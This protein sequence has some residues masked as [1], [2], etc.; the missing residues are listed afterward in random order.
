M[1]LFDYTCDECGATKIDVLVS[2]GAVI[3]LCPLSHGPMR[4]H[5]PAPA[6]HVHGFNCKNG[7]AGGQTYE[8]KSKEKNVRV[9][10]KS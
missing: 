3:V 6:F 5:F 7:Y 2:S 8:V 9:V 1:P 4:R 10:V